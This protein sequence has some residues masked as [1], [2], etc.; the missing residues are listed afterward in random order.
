MPV[1]FVYK[2]RVC[3]GGNCNQLPRAG[4]FYSTNGCIFK[5]EA[6]MFCQGVSTFNNISAVIYLT[7]V[8]LETEKKL[9]CC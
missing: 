4:D 3:G 1:K 2:G 7:D 6:V 8:T 9:K 5:I